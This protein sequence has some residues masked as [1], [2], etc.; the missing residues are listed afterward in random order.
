MSLQPAD[1]VKR[2]S[3]AGHRVT[4]ARVAVIEV[5]CGADAM[6]DSAE[7]LRRAQ[8]RQRHVG[9]ATVYRTLDMLEEIG[10]IRRVQIDGR[11]HVVACADHSLHFHLICEKCHVVTELHAAAE[12]SL[13]ALAH[14]Q[15]FAPSL[16]PVEIIGR[17]ADCRCVS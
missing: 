1:L 16:Q 3:A 15:G 13:L 9:L 12:R 14:A 5:V 6:L 8:L 11:A 2:L 10:A 7:I 17:C 4:Q